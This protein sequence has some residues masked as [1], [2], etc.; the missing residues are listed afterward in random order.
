MMF[1]LDVVSLLSYYWLT[2]GKII[3]IFTKNHTPRDGVAYTDDMSLVF[4]SFARCDVK[5]ED[6]IHGDSST[7]YGCYIPQAIIFQEMVTIS[8]LLFIVLAVV[9]MLELVYLC[10]VC[11]VPCLGRSLMTCG[12]TVANIYEER[13]MRVVSTGDLLALSYIRR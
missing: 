12:G 6:Y 9:T 3:Q 13:V 10:A 4:P 7:R 5:E 8:V 2:N 11:F 1:I